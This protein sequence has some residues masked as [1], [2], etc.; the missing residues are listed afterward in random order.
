MIPLVAASRIGGSNWWCRVTSSEASC[1]LPSSWLVSE[2]LSAATGEVERL[3]R[4]AHLT[5]WASAR[6][7]RRNGVRN[8]DDNLQM[9][10]GSRAADRFP[11]C[12]L[13]R[14]LRDCREPF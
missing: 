6:I 3:M 4:R 7:V 9:D 2:A 13:R 8:V 5:R 14:G 10:F 11:V 1:N 12:A